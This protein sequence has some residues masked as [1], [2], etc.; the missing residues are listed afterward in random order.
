MLVVVQGPRETIMRKP[1]ILWI[2]LLTAV[3]SLAQTATETSPAWKK[4]EFLLGNWTGAAGESPAGLGAG[5]GSFSF[6]A[7]LNRQIMVRRSR[8]EYTSGVRH[9]DLMV[10]YFDAPKDTPRAIYFDSEGHVIRYNAAF[11]AA[12]VVIFESE[13][14]LAGPRYRLKY[15]RDGAALNGQFEIAEAGSKYKT[16]LTW[17]SRKD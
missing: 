11:P 6:E 14:T 2:M 10:I 15:W 7:D 13:K 12:N 1:R 9:D 4:L 5:Q 3:L 16:Y 17:T 8:S